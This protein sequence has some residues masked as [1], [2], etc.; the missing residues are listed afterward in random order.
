MNTTEHSNLYR[1][2]VFG[3]ESS[4]ETD[5]EIAALAVYL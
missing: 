4:V 3:L 1:Y 2:L 5:T